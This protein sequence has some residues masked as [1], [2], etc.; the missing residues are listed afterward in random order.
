MFLFKGFQCKWQT[1]RGR[2]SRI[3]I[4]PAWLMRHL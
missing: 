4:Q 3:N 1:L 2:Q